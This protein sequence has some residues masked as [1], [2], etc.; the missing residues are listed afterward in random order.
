MGEIRHRLQVDDLQHRVGWAFDQHELGR[1]GERGLPGAEV[2][3]VDENGIDA[4]ARQQGGDDPVT[5]AEQSARRH[6]AIARLQ[7]GEQ[8]RGDGGHAGGRGA[9]G[10]RAFQ[11]G[12]P[13][14]QHLHRRVAEARILEMLDLAEEGLLGLLGAVIDKA[15]GEKERLARLAILAAHGAAMDQKAGG[16]KGFGGCGHGNGPLIEKPGRGCSKGASVPT[17]LFSAFLSPRRNPAGQ[18]TRGTPCHNPA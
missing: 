8:R 1:R 12:E 11:K 10:F 14:F 7:M 18:I 9:A 15:G 5:G 13:A 6:H 4:V 17:G 2:G 3:A 16:A